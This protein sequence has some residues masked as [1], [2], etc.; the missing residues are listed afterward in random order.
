MTEKPAAPQGPRNKPALHDWVLLAVVVLAALAAWWLLHKKG[1]PPRPGERNQAAGPQAPARPLLDLATRVGRSDATILWL[2]D[3]TVLRVV[4]GGYDNEARKPL[5]DSLVRLDLSTGRQTTLTDLMALY[6]E[7]FARHTPEPSPDGQ[8]LLWASG[9]QHHLVLHAATLDGKRHVHTPKAKTEYDNLYVYWLGDSRRFVELVTPDCKKFTQALIHDVE[10]P[11]DV[12][13]IPIPESSPLQW[14][15]CTTDDIWVAAEDR[16]VMTPGGRPGAYGGV[17]PALT[18]RQAGL[19]PALGWSSV[20][21]VRPP[22][23]SV[24]LCGLALSPRSDRIG[25]LIAREKEKGPTIVSLWVSRLDGTGWRE[26]GYQE[27]HK[28]DGGFGEHLLHFR[29]S[30]PGDLRWVPDGK[31]LS[32]S[33][34]GGLYTVPAD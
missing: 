17:G 25:W 16:L 9:E 1:G 4:Q 6:N 20:S 21:T 18:I 7:A 3:S 26:I 23:E 34:K 22:P 33:Y 29:A 19:D 5:P 13:V 28:I 8:W 27:T 11:D 15:C 30:A 10:A 24:M 12:K 14:A 32:F 2:D 31:H